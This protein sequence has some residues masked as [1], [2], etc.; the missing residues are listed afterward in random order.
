MP[1]YDLEIIA[2]E[3]GA[4]TTHGW[5]VEKYGI[6]GIGIATFRFNDK[7]VLRIKVKNT[8]YGISEGGVKK[9]MT[10]YP[11]SK[12]KAKGI[13]LYVIPVSIMRVLEEL[14]PV[15]STPKENETDNQSS[16]F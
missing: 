4:G 12:Y 16:L 8:I 15:V 5:D 13:L 3:W 1:N 10:E 14:E 6:R 2:P 7:K 9:F 11:K